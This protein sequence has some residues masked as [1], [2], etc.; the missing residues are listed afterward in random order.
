MRQAGLAKLGHV[1]L[2]D[3]EEKANAS[4]H[5]SMSYKRLSEKEAQLKRE[6]AE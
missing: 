6:V 4:K 1:A 3:T 2:D 5:K